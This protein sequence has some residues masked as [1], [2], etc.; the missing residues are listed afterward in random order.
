MLLRY[1]GGKSRGALSRTII[2]FIR[3]RYEGGSFGE[4]FFGGGGI[5]FHLLKAHA[6]ERLVI[7]DLDPA[8]AKLWSKVITR[9]SDLIRAVRDFTPSVEAFVSAKKRLLSGHGSAFD[10]LVANRLSHCG[11]G[12]LAGPQG[13]YRQDGQYKIDCRWNARSLMVEIETAHGLLTSVPVQC[14]NKHYSK[15]NC[16]FMYLDPPYFEKGD[17]LYPCAF[18]VNDHIDLAKFV[19]S[20]E[21]WVLSYNNHPFV[22][23]LYSDYKRVTQSVAGNGGNKPDSE[24][25]I[26]SEKV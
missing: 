13:G 7:N 11:R 17:D 25:I 9:P 14:S 8:I 10:M 12:V 24:L 18:T 3:A 2:D 16:N 1:P 5:T 23:S 15:F 6:I 26:L 22:R 19:S 21:N 4:L 20:R